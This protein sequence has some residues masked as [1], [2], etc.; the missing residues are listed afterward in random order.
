MSEESPTLERTEHLK[1]RDG[2]V[3]NLYEHEDRAAAIKAV[4]VEQ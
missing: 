2:K 1:V 3:V 4:G